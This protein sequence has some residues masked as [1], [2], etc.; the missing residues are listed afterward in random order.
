MPDFLSFNIKYL[1]K[2]KGLTQEEFANK[3]DVKRSVIGAYEEGR[4]EPKLSTIQNIADYY[5]ITIDDLINSDLSKKSTKK[6][7][8][9]L[10]LRILP[11]MVDREEDKEL[12]T[13]VPVKAAAGYLN[14]YADPEYVE[15]LPAFR[16]PFPE[17]LNKGTIRAFQIKGDSMLPIPPHAYIISEYIQDWKQ[18]KDGQSYVFIT[19][20]DGIVYKRAY[21]RI[22]EAEEILL[23]SDNPEYEAYSIKINDVI[24]IW[25]ALGYVSFEL[26]N[27]E[28]DN[29]SLQKLSAMVM[30]LKSEMEK[31]K[32]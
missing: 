31:I 3:I 5:Q 9:G 6:D 30:Q 4:A 2:S 27:P 15:A 8:G 28:S 22:N 13:L 12:V 26:P 17:V 1:R 14:G 7:I 10:G 29:V 18:L 25:K 19:K 21:N 16:L 23:K 11:I 32:K 20:N 24:E